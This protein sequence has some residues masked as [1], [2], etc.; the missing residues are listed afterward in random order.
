MPPPRE[1]WCHLLVQEVEDYA[2]FGL[3][4]AGRVVSWNAGAERIKGYHAEEILG[5]SFSRFYPEEDV[6]RGKPE[7]N[8]RIAEEEGRFTDEGW[9]VRKDGSKFWAD[10]VITALRGADGL[11]RGFAKVT[12]DAT[13]RKRA[14]DEIRRLNEDL[15]R[16]VV[17]RTAEL[18]AAN[19]ELES[20]AYSV[21][22]DLKAPLRA[23]NG[24]AA[25]VRNRYG[26]ELNDEVRHYLDNIVQ[27]GERLDRL[28]DA[29]LDYS[30]LGREGVRREAV[31][32]QEILAEILEGFSA[33]IAQ[34]DAAVVLPEDL[35]VVRGDPTLLTQIFWSLLDN[36]LLYRRREVPLHVTVSW[37]AEGDFS[38]VAV[39]DNGIG[40]PPE[41]R[42]MIFN[43]FQRLHE[44]DEYP[45]TGIGL[46]RVKKSAEL[47]GGRVWVEPTPGGGSTFRI[48][49][50]GGGGPDVG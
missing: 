44:D 41:H 8:L 43:L 2:I 36:A 19:E 17:E 49:L 10:V 46:A 48:R 4:P 18:K 20:F 45:G 7:R 23:I 50:P 35:P 24:F 1:D 11:L 16:R 9:R 33:R 37:Q 28:I 29:L 27:A 30:R 34:S 40:I 15:E 25:I 26:D 21:S 22:H 12:R 32:L 42:E 39:A 31:P 38:T 47:L 6:E 13:D 5:E 3:D 14:Q